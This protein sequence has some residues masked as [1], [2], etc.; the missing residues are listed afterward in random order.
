MR[1]HMLCGLVNPAPSNESP[2]KLTYYA[3]NKYEVI[4]GYFIAGN[5]HF[6]NN[7]SLQLTSPNLRLS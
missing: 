5:C 1:C 3:N 4:Y 7:I 2:L 6:H